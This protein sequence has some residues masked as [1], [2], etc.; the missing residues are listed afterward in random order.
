MFSISTFDGDPPYVAE[1]RPLYLVVLLYNLPYPINLA[2]W[3][4]VSP[5][6]MGQ[7]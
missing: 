4:R 2:S 6:V 3:D 1:T 5:M 7:V